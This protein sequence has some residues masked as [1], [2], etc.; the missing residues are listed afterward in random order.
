MI[1]TLGDERLLVLVLANV[2]LLP[3]VVP[4][5]AS[6]LLLVGVPTLVL[7]AVLAVLLVPRAVVIIPGTLLL[8]ALGGEVTGLATVETGPRSCLSVVEGTLELVDDQCKI[9]VPKH[10]QLLICHRHK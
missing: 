7:V 2:L 3:L 6:T 8:G 5:G 10:L 9:L 1:L 4:L